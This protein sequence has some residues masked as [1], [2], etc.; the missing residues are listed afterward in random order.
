MKNSTSKII[1]ILF[2]ASIFSSCSIDM[3]N[4]V[5]GNRNVITQVRKTSETFTKISV[6]SGIDLYINQG[7]K[8]KVVVEADKNLHDIIITKVEDGTLKVYSEKN[9][10]KAKARKVF[11]TVK[12]LTLLKATSGSDVYS[13][14]TIKTNNIN[15]SATSGADI[16]ITVN[17]I[18]VDTNSTSGANIEI[19]GTAI[20]HSSSATSGSSIDAYKL[21]SKNA[22]ARVT[23]GADV[24]IYASEKLEA[25]ATSGGDIDFK[26]SPKSVH[27][28][29]N[30]GG[31]I[32]A[33]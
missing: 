20:N 30:S 22:N 12:D 5:S 2:L 17:A 26:G 7:S 24:N 14:N 21:N 19:F 23:S 16:K 6:S 15:I 13:E 4:G 18:N 8:N 10:W 9:I 1:V 25:T 11:V 27:K 32:S 33:K 29:S 3:F 28:N 31:S